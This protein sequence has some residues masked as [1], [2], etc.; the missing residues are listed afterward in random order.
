MDS[1]RNCFSL[2]SWRSQLTLVLG[3]DSQLGER[4]AVAAYYVLA[5]VTGSD[6]VVF[7]AWVVLAWYSPESRLGWAYRC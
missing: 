4:D 1:R 6:L 5:R 2:I 7:L 3:W